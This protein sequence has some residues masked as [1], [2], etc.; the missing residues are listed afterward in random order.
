MLA[1]QEMLSL[2]C[3]CVESRSPVP[4]QG[5]LAVCAV[6]FTCAHV[7]DVPTLLMIHCGSSRDQDLVLCLQYANPDIVPRGFCALG[8]KC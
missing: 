6:G 1:D 3:L 5:C 8:G 7:L 4:V 2:Q